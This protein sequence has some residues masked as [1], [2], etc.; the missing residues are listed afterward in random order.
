MKKHQL[1]PKKY[2]KSKARNLPFG[3]CLI[4]NE[5]QEKGMAVVYITKK[6]P[7]GKNIIGLYIVDVFCLG[8]K[9]T[10]YHFG[11]ED[12]EAEEFKTDVSSKHEMVPISV[13]EAHNIIYGSID[14]AEELGFKPHKDFNITEYILDPDHIDDGIDDIEFGK[15]GKPYFIAGPDDNI[16]RILATLDQNVGED[17]YD[18]F[19]DSYD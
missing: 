1:S 15:N 19:V 18:Y 11:L 8:L 3:D 6:M 17:N 9:N 10:L 4:N 13:N 7:S 12:Y 14:Y 16:N 2:I 5:W